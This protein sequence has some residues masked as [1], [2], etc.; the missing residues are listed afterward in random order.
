MADSIVKRK[1]DDAETITTLLRQ[2]AALEQELAKTE[3]A[4]QV[5]VLPTG[6]RQCHP[7]GLE[8]AEAPLP[9]PPSSRS[10]PPAGHLVRPRAG[11]QEGEQEHREP[12]QTAP[13]LRGRMGPR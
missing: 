1:N 4:L 13:G 6:C 3:E 12:Q 5:Q 9:E 10:N 2:T 7:L 11:G 8:V